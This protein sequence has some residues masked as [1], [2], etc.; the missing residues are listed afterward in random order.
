MSAHLIETSALLRFALRA[1]GIV[2]LTAGVLTCALLPALPAVFGASSAHLLAVGIF[3]AAY[4]LAVGALSRRVRMDQRLMGGIVIGNAGWVLASLCLPLSGWITP[5][6]IGVLLIVGQAL[7]V[8]MLSLLQFLGL[9]QSRQ[10]R[11]K[12]PVPQMS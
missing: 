1:D 10:S 7:L 5:T 4:G 11:S 3:M 12:L 6:A 8:A 2:S 9:R